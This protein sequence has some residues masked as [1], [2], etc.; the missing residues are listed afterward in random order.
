MEHFLGKFIELVRPRFLKRASYGLVPNIQ[1][2]P[3]W[4]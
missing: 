3:L 1:M 4:D 2:V